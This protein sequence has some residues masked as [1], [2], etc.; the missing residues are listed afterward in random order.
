MKKQ[1]RDLAYFD[2]YKND[3][4][5]QYGMRNIYTFPNGY[6]ASVVDGMGSY[7]LEL[8]VLSEDA[9]TYETPITD[10]VLGHLTQETLTDALNQIYNLEQKKTN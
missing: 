10:D 9:I 2:K 1:Y 3:I 7:G 6:G 5:D 4:S 8:A